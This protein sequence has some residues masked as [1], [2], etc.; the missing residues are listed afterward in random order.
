V[1]SSLLEKPWV[2]RTIAIIAALPF[3]YVLYYN[4]QIVDLTIPRVALLLQ[5]CLLVVTMLIRRAPVRVT[6]NPVYWLVAFV[7]SY[8]GFLTVAVS[9]SGY[10]L[11]PARYTGMLSIASVIA[12]GYAR[13]TLGRNIGFVPA[14]RRLVTGGPYRFVRHPIYSALFLA[15]CCVVLENFSPVNLVLSLIFLSLFVIKTLMEE[16]FLRLDPAYARYMEEVR[17]RWIPG[18][19]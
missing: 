17:Y 14:Q 15:E 7:A 5:L 3:I 11:V 4:V 18:V 19:L 2:D 9:A 12:D 8:Y 1:T 10:P 16:N 13:V 6:T